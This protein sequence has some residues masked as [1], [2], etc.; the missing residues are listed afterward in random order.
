MSHLKDVLGTFG[1]AVN[2]LRAPRFPN[3]SPSEALVRM[4]AVPDVAQ[5][6]SG[7]YLEELRGRL[8]RSGF[9]G[10]EF[11]HRDIRDAP[12]VLWD[13]KPGLASTH[14]GVLRLVLDRASSHRRTL[15][16]LIEAWIAAFASH[17]DTIVESGRR[18]ASMLTTNPDTRLDI[19]RTA[20]GKLAFFAAEAGPGRVAER[21]LQGPGE[22]T[23]VLGSVG[24]SEPTRSVSGYAREVHR[25]LLEAC[26]DR[27]SGRSGEQGLARTIAFLAPQGSLRFP[28][29]RGE[30]ARVLTRPWWDGTVRPT[31][32][33]LTLVCDFLVDHLRDPRTNP[34]NWQAAGEEATGLVRRWVVR[35][36]LD[37]FFGLIEQFALDEH[38]QW[39]AAFWK[40]CMEKCNQTGVPFDAW[41]ALGPRVRDTAR[42]SR[43]LKGAFGRV[44]GAGVQAN[45]SVLIMRVGPITF[46]DW[47]HNGAL[48]AW[49]T[50]WK[51][52]P[53]LGRPEYDRTE[54][55]GKCLPFPPN[56]RFG[57]G[58][59]PDGKGLRHY[60]SEQGYWQGSAASLLTART[61]IRLT[62]SD[63]QPR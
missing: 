35:A 53:R 45:H 44:V 40:A 63:W 18:I 43:E 49:P 8:T 7:P 10:G 6:A 3:P 46:C 24:L 26:A 54:L 34:G 16:N 15:V 17:D 42:T 2:L 39:R 29:H 50:D 22:V 60:G 4:L 59:D 55:T 51:N 28:E 9:A 11:A 48:R 19:W 30:V 58:G 47:S 5:K 32:S 14:P 13:T 21:L 57:K 33:L 52:A 56:P 27:L 23:D 36:S 38:W 37:L 20:H 12:W 25:Y 62:P 61:G 31:D 41:V 1:A